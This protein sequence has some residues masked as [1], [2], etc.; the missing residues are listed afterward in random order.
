MTK[1]E[2]LE[3][4]QMLDRSDIEKIFNCK[5]NKALEII[6]MIKKVS[7]IANFKGR[8]TVSDYEAWINRRSN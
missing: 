1:Q 3:N 4:T 8:V 5:R 7:N 2:I 6:Q